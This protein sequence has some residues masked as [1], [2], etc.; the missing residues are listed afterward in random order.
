MKTILR[1]ITIYSITMVI[2]YLTAV[3][4]FANF[5]IKEWDAQN[6]QI[7]FSCFAFLAIIICTA[8]E[9]FKINN[10]ETRL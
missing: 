3:L 8:S 10:N 2:G 1:V 9:S 5:N 6:R 4:L 7:V